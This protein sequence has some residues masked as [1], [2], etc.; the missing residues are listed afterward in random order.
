MKLRGLIKLFLILAAVFGLAA[1]AWGAEAVIL[2]AS[3][4]P[5]VLLTPAGGMREAQ[6]LDCLAAG[7]RLRLA[8]GARLVVYFFEAGFREEIQGPGLATVT[9][10]TL[11][12]ADGARQSARTELE[13]V[14]P[15][16]F[17]RPPE[18]SGAGLVRDAGRFVSGLQPISPTDTAVRSPDFTFRWNRPDE[19]D[20]FRLNLSVPL[21]PSL[22]DVRTRENSYQ[23]P[24]ENLSPGV[25]YKWTVV[26]QKDGVETTR[27]EGRFYLLSREARNEATYAEQYVRDHFPG[28][29]TEKA[30][31]LVLLY[32]QY[33]LNDEARQVLLQLRQD[34]PE[35]DNF[36]RQLNELADNYRR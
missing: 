30:V 4:T 16:G 35:N 34:M 19:A 17:C 23:C 24:L 9:Q 26:A 7:D 32:R 14:L 13:S 10:E 22:L 6:A 28:G 33:E 25:E 29:P 20:S 15:A 11:T 2:D 27:A 36:A 12:L 5:A 21:N 18:R 3:G 1:S 31:A 8:E